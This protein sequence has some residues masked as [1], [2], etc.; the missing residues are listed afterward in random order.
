MKAA[1]CA[2]IV[3]LW[4]ALSLS[5]C[6]RN[7]QSGEAA[8]PITFKLP[9]SRVGRGVGNLKHLVVLPALYNAGWS[10]SFARV[11]C[12]TSA[13]FIRN[14]MAGQ[15]AKFL[16]SSKDYRIV[17]TE[18]RIVEGASTSAEKDLLAEYS[19][20][21]FEARD[22]SPSAETADLARR[23]GAIY[24]A[25]GIVLVHGDY[26]SEDP[27]TVSLML[28]GMAKPGLTVEAWIFETGS[29]RMVWRGSSWAPG[30]H[31]NVEPA[32]TDLENAIPDVMLR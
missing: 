28:F 32:F 10:E 20:R 11:Y 9:P 27:I 14:A 1:P 24:K 30:C 15:A 7:W 3:V 22:G 2:L 13:E 19:R 12:V 26:T 29:G 6:T 8:I 25:D 21:L 23:I 4:A 18:D 5:G 16:A 31:W 17:A